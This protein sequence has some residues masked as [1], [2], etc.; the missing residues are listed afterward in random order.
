MT[1]LQKFLRWDVST[2]AY[3]ICRGCV[4]GYPSLYLGLVTHCGLDSSGPLLE[5]WLLSLMSTLVMGF[6]PE[7]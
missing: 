1:V 7:D 5:D 3:Y 6:G 4:C 2:L